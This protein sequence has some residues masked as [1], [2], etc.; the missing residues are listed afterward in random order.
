MS[1]ESFAAHKLILAT[2]SPV[3]MAQFYGQM[4][5]KSSHRVEVKDMEAAVFNALLRFIYTDAVPEFDG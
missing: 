1:G 2:R 4:M 5:E 3:F